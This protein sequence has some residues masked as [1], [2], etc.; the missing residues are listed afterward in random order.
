M[1]KVRYSIIIPC[2]GSGLW[3]AELVG[4]ISEVMESHKPYE[5]ILVN[6]RSPD[7]Q[8]WAE[9]ERIVQENDFVTGIDLLYNV[10]QFTATI[11]GIDHASGDY[12]ITMDDDLQHPP[13]ELP[14]LI[15]AMRENPEMDCVMGEYSARKDNWLRKAGSRLLREIINRLYDKPKSVV[16]T[17][18]RIMP[19]E[20]AKSLSL[21]RIASPQLGPLIVSQ[22]RKIMNVKVQ[23]NSREFGSSGYSLMKCVKETVLSV[24]NA[25]LVPL[26]IFTLAGFAIALA[27]LVIGV[28]FLVRRIA[29]G[30]GVPGYTSLI[31][32]ML[33]LGGMTLAGIGVLGEYV[34]RI[35]RELTGMPKYQ[36]RKIAGEGNDGIG[37]GTQAV[38]AKTE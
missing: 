11:C 12:V 34:G 14:K 15:T 20:F 32:A 33:M 29:G 30:I 35:I 18:F 17:S 21:Y 22:S 6:D 26:R 8:T 3:L 23:H 24:I 13:S 5:V 37:Q 31:L 36:V 38:S 28:Y 27:A 4:Q 16:T 9:I 7:P 25:S 10:G 1:S 2:Y 19:A